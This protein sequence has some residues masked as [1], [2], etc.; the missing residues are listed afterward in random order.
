MVRN[1]LPV[2]ASQYGDPGPGGQYD[3]FDDFTLSPPAGA[4]YADIQ[5]LYQTTSWEY[6]QFLDLA[7]T[8]AS[9]F[10]ADEGVNMLEAWLNTGMSAPYVM[11]STV[12]GDAPTPTVPSIYA[13]DIATWSVS[14]KG[15]LIAESST[16]GSGDKVAITV[17]VVDEGGSPISGAQVFF[18]VRD[19][20]G[21]LATA[22]Q[23]FTD[24]QGH[25]TLL[26]KIS[27]KQS[28]D[29]FV[30]TITD[31]LENSYLYDPAM[32]VSTVSFLVQ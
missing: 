7:N 12:W 19:S 23:G 3:Y 24:A 20:S 28:P 1:A 22:I 10:L 25:A 16:F 13:A 15:S 29:A 31:I 9:A 5:L 26:W 18:E 21:G 32:G 17:D 8:G 30:A 2:P 14:K 4:T 6:I 27:Q 11:A